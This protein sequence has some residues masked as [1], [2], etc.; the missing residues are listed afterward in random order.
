[1]RYAQASINVL[2]QSAACNA[3]HSVPARTARWLLQSQDRAG[4]DE[5]WLTQEFLSRMLGVRRASVTEVASDLQDD[6]TITYTRG[7]I[8][9]LDRS[10]LEEKSCE[11]H[12]LITEEF[13][14]VFGV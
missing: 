14:R 11:C 7:H 13:E 8:K 5:F 9:V 10:I 12:Q 6:G 1:L 2:A 4:A 3:L